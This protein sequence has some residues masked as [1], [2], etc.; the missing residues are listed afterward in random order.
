MTN[1]MGWTVD[2]DQILKFSR[3]GPRYTSYPTAPVWSDDIGSDEA[4]AAYDRAA[5][6]PDAPLSLYVH[7]PFCRRR[8]LFCGCTVEI[9][10]QQD[11]VTRYLDV[12]E[13]EI[14]TVAKRLGDRRNVTQM[15]WG[16][17]T[18]THLTS[19]ELRRLH[20]VLTDRFDLVDG[21]EVSI[22][23]HPHVTND[24]QIDTLLEL[25]FNRISMGVQDTDKTV[26][27]VIHRDQTVEDTLRC[28]E[29]FR[30]HGVDGINL[31]LM[32]GLPEQTEATFGATLDT[33]ASIRPDRLAIYGYAHVPWLK[34]AQ[35]VLEKAGLP[36][37]VDR[38]RLFALAVEQLSEVGYEVIGL[39]HFALPTDSLYRSL[40]D[41]T[42]ERN[43]MGYTSQRAGDMVAFGASAIGDVGGAFLQ[44]ARKTNTYAEAIGE[45]RLPTVRGL[46]RS[47]DDDLR[48]AIIQSLM[49]RMRLDLDEIEEELQV[50]GLE[51]RFEREFEE[52][53]TFEAE[54]LC[55][56][57]KRLVRVL[58]RGR[59]FLRHLAMAFDAYLDRSPASSQS[60]PSNGATPRFSQTV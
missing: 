46:V 43:F 32:Y 19:A 48:R 57:D 17:G 29:R 28:V 30:A 2:A 25:G 52:L 47:E 12:L 54:G 10:N 51:Q 45:G 34:P 14:D 44:N 13:W 33:I 50:T 40:L 23:I 49:C 20:G 15:H 31:D 55:A 26:Q 27:E 3:P 42:L 59:L 39:D 24:D 37:A 7:L 4:L 60:A 18:P 9:T 21:A 35:E 22:E 6:L 38:A 16:G 11:R 5:Q 58:P 1:S 41:G 36:D 53:R 8:C 56:V